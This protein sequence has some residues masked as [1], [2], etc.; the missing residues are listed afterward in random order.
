MI[1]NLTLSVRRW[2]IRKTTLAL[3]RGRTA[4]LCVARGGAG[5]TAGRGKNDAFACGAARSARKALGWVFRLGFVTGGL[6]ACDGEDRPR[7]APTSS[8]TATPVPSR[9]P[10]ASATSTPTPTPTPPL[11]DLVGSVV[12]SHCERDSCAPLFLDVCVQNIGEGDAPSSV[13][14]INPHWGGGHSQRIGALAAGARTCTAFNYDVFLFSV[15][16]HFLLVDAFQEVEE[17]NELNNRLD[18]PQPSGTQCDIICTDEEA[19]PVRTPTP[20]P[21]P[22]NG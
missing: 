22:S 13:V 20:P 15:R 17:S 2:T 3:G 9:T 1:V 10:T 6:I 18:Y 5:S 12:G 16:E 19:R 8:P 21:P 14:T 11:P 7:A 4:L